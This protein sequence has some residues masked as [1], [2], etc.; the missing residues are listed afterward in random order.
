VLLAIGPADGEAACVGEALGLADGVA[1][2][3]AGA[4]GDAE[5]ATPLAEGAI[6]TLGSG[7]CGGSRPM[8]R[9]Q[10]D[11]VGANL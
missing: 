3:L 6:D 9:Q 11:R 7:V 5:A 2:P 10:A 8:R 1:L 4:L